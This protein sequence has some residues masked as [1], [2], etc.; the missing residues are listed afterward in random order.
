MADPFPARGFTRLAY[1]DS[2]D[3]VFGHAPMPVRAGF[4][5]TIG[6][7]QVYPEVNFTLPPMA[8]SDATWAEVRG[9]YE[10]IGEGVVKRALA[11][12]VPGIVLEFE[13]LPPMTERPEW[14]AEITAI[15]RRHLE[16]AHADHGLR[17]ALRATITDL[18]DQV[19]PPLLR[20]GDAWDKVKR[21]FELCADAGAHILSIESVGGKEVHDE[22]LLYG[23][24]RG[25]VVRA[26]RAVLPRHG[27]VVGSDRGGVSGAAGGHPGR[28]H[29]LRLC[30]HRHATRP[31][32]D[33]PRGVGG[34][35]SGHDRAAQPGGVRAGRRRSVQGLCLRGARPEGD[36][37][38]ADRHGGEVGH[39]RPLQPPGQHRRRHVRPVE[40]RVGA[41]RAPAVGER[42]GG[43]R[44]AAGLRLPPDEPGHWPRRRADAAGLVER[45]RP[46]A[47]SAGGHSLA[48][49]DLGDRP[50]D[51]PRAGRLSAHR[52]CR[53][54]RRPTPE[55]RGPDRVGSRWP[56]RSGSG[57]TEADAALAE[58]PA[59]EHALLGEMH[60]R[61]RAPV[62]AGELRPEHRDVQPSR[63][64][65]RPRHG[66]HRAEGESHEHRPSRRSWARHGGAVAVALQ[67]SP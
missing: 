54:G 45:I 7:G 23:D 51:R 10:E 53:H 11:L 21:S 56:R 26:R 32:G 52:G 20:T 19:R 29:G 34:R 61:V 30:E 63:L 33:A 44:R 18:R 15:L 47:E 67:Y 25:L 5:L 31:S 58:L 57:W 17:S 66:A 48:R 13:L 39:L 16:R 43:L 40:Q 14:G 1:N 60:G 27:L 49:G 24:V 64:S 8:I 6:A 36:H 46:V 22:A 9:H 38:C 35:G 3:L 65:R 55:G 41:E 37:R 2:R 42:A 62:L 12:Q 59:E 4:D 28:G 50:G